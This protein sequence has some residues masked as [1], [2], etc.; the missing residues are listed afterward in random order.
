MSDLKREVERIKFE[1]SHYKA[2]TIRSRS[3][4]KELKKEVDKL[5]FELSQTKEQKRQSVRIMV[6]LVAEIFF[7]HESCAGLIDNISDKGVLMRIAPMKKQVNFSP[8]KTLDVKMRI[9]SRETLNTVCKVIW[10]YKTLPYQ[11]IDC[12]GVE[13]K[14]PDSKYKAFFKSLQESLVPEEGVKPS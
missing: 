14:E 8:G 6:S 10:S 9:S 12:L 2:L 1:L 5:K 4:V 13:I 11:M 3:K 7:E